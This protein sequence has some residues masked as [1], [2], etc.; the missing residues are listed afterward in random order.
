MHFARK[1]SC[2]PVHG[3]AL[4]TFPV[5]VTGFLITL[6]AA[7]AQTDDPP[8]SVLY[9]YR[10][11]VFSEILADPSPQLGL[12]DVE[13]VELY[14]RTVKPADLRGWTFSDAVISTTLPSF[15]L[16]P[17]GYAIVTAASGAAQFNMPSNTLGVSSFPSLN[18][19]GDVIVLRDA[20]GNLIDSL[21]YS[22]AWYRDPG[23]SEGGWSL[24]LIDPQN[25]CEDAENWVAAT[26]ASG[27]TP[28][29]EN[30]VHAHK[31][32]NM[33]PRILE[34]IAMDSLLIIIRFNEKLD[35]VTP[36]LSSFIIQPS[37]EIS[38]VKF[39]DDAH[40]ALKVVL[41]EPIIRSE[42]YTI[43]VRGIY[44]CPGNPIQEEFSRASFVLPE[45]A[46]A[47]DIVVNEV[48]FNP[49]PT[50]VDFVEVFNRSAKVID[51]QNWSVR[52]ALTGSGK[53]ET[54][55]TSQPAL[56]Y[57]GD[58]K[59]F[60]SK[61][62]V[63]KGEYISTVEASVVETAIP[64]LNDD[65]GSVA[66]V[67]EKGSLID[68]I[69]YSDK[70]H[71]PFVQEDEG[72]SLE[73]IAA[74]TSG[75]EGSNWASASSASGFATPGYVNSNVRSDVFS[76]DGPV[77]VEPEIIRLHVYQNDFARIL[78]RFQRGGFVANVR[79][80]DQQGRTV[81]QLAANELLGTEGFFRWDGDRQDGSA[82]G[83]GYY[84]V[85]F[86]V[87]DADGTVKTYRRRVSIF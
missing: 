75:L 3:F 67:D 30:S 2:K 27:G 82:A 31:P 65:E 69:Y 71:S 53:S 14:N 85:W 79:V 9:S 43:T 16:P 59:V 42:A 12:P 21:K 4:K 49:R 66:L 23:K 56:L 68:S 61:R 54:I 29:Q 20:E 19:A 22:Q 70:M 72:I 86:E 76:G 62:N 11:V 47:G 55:A 84:M 46:E 58:F 25:I 50:G 38:S 34:A 74:H 48:L 39:F 26:A 80:Y 52:N 28:G 44:D 37:I 51:V 6:Q 10:D 5:L 64:P 7:S 18:N 33:G 63:L 24:E 45:A 83:T 73:R 41:S 17:G 78:Y 40:S 13:F 32:D 87:F 36:P 57:P 60:T 8:A 81:R 35:A 77:T 15:I 1:I